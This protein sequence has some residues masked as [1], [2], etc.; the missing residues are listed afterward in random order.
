MQVLVRLARYCFPSGATNS[1]PRL[2]VTLLL[3]G[4]DHVVP[5]IHQHLHVVG[6]HPLRGHHALFILLGQFL[7][8]RRI[9]TW[10]RR[11]HGF[12]QVLPQRDGD[13]HQEDHQ[14]GDDLI[15]VEELLFDLRALGK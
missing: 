3:L 10:R 7:D 4:A 9:E 14:A 13:H 11:R 5:P 6:S 12:P 1:R 15:A 2:V 8:D